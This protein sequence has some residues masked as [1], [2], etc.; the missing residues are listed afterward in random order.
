MSPAWI[1]LSFPLR[2]I[3]NTCQ[4]KNAHV[5]LV[6]QVVSHTTRLWLHFYCDVPF[7]QSFAFCH[8]HCCWLH[9]RTCKRQRRSFASLLTNQVFWQ[10]NFQIP[11]SELFWK[12]WTPTFLEYS[13]WKLQKMSPF[14]RKSSDGVLFFKLKNE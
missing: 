12:L 9:I 13:D 4:H 5:V 6:R 2:Q 10:E 3:R 11:K 1:Y 8:I 7:D 14:M